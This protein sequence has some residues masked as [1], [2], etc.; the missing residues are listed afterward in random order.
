MRRM[1]RELEQLLV[2]IACSQLVI[3]LTLHLNSCCLQRLIWL[4][5]KLSVSLDQ[6][7]VILIGYC[8]CHNYYLFSTNCTFEDGV[9]GTEVHQESSTSTVKC[10]NQK[11]SIKKEQ[12]VGFDTSLYEN[13][14]RRRHAT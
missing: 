7:G 3:Y 6:S 8:F 13:T 5:C 11:R 10:Q 4:G 1:R 12:S 9:K 14:L 2:T